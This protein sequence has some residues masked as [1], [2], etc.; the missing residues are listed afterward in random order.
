MKHKNFALIVFVIVVIGFSLWWFMQRREIATGKVTDTPIPA[1]A[2]ATPASMVE[3]PELAPATPTAE[4]IKPVSTA[5]APLAMDD[6]V[7]I[8]ARL[9]EVIGNLQKNAPLSSR[10]QI[11]LDSL[12]AVKGHSPVI[13][14]TGNSARY[15]PVFVDDKQVQVVL[16]KRNGG[17]AI[18]YKVDDGLQ[19]PA[20][21][22]PSGTATSN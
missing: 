12:L 16:I 7:A 13:D 21:N 19:S 10:L 22:H 17:W 6:P 20:T 3:Q 8:D 5:T 11:Q 14:G 9:A 4:T 2:A 1:Q 15:D 18:N